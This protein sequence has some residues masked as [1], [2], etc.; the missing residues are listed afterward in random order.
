VSPLRSATAVQIFVVPAS[1]SLA[2]RRGFAR[3]TLASLF[4]ARHNIVMTNRKNYFIRTS[5]TLALLLTAA[6]LPET[7]ASENVPYRP[8]AYW[9]DVPLK[10]QFVVGVVYQQSE[11]YHIWAHGKQ[12]DIT[13][14][15]GDG[16]Y[17]GIDNTQ[18]FL[19]LQYGITEKWAA[20]LN[21]GYATVGWRSFSTNQ[22]PQSTGGLMDYSFG[23]RYQAFNEADYTNSPWVPTLTFRAGA[24]MAGTYDQDFI[25]APGLRSMAIVPEVLLRKSFGWPGLG[26]YGDALYRWN[27]TTANDQFVTEIGLFQKIKGWELD[28]G[29]RHLQTIS[30]NDIT[31]TDP[32][33][34]STINYPRD[35][36]EINDSIAAGFSYTTSKHH[37]RYGFES[38]TTFLGNNTH[39]EFWL[40]AS[41]DI[42]IGG[43]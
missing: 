2:S 33:D 25:F 20:D 24:V 17:Y 32:S 18:G 26:V 22:S 23:V 27:H 38:R 13:T 5:T 11:A 14:K 34:L 40:G 39:R 42:P 4:L 8:F 7:R 15:A 10:G 19:A 28:A 16:E 6:L 12:V 41:I 9:A 36:R 31:F 1:F 30:G 21:V 35:P 43:H 3:V 29:W 37:W